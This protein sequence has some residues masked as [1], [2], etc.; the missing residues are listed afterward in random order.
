ML[1]EQRLNEAQLTSSEKDI[2]DYIIAHKYELRDLSTRNIAKETFTSSATIVRFSKKLGYQGFNELK[3][4][5][6]KEL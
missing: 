2:G 1:F 3:E 6:I 5:Y 4:D